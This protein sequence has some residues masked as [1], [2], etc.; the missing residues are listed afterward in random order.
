MKSA[1][2]KA[3]LSEHPLRAPA[4]AG[5]G[6]RVPSAPVLCAQLLTKGYG[7][8]VHHSS[9]SLILDSRICDL[10]TSPFR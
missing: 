10:D 6:P 4:F 7:F 3:H 5:L 9:C 8:H 1:P 2:V